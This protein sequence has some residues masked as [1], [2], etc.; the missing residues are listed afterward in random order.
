MLAACR[1]VWTIDDD[2]TFGFGYGYGTLPGHPECGEESFVIRRDG[3]GVGF[4]VDAFSR[5][6]QAVARLGGPITRALQVRTLRAY[7]TGMQRWVA[8]SGSAAR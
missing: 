5:P 4:E 7:L 6:R 1:I 8:G 2:R 3:T